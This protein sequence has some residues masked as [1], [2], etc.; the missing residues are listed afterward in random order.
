VLT[1][2]LLILHTAGGSLHCAHCKLPMRATFVLLF[3][4]CWS[5][6]VSALSSSSGLPVVK[7]ATVRR[8][9]RYFCCTNKPPLLLAQPSVNVGIKHKARNFRKEEKHTDGNSGGVLGTIWKGI[10]RFLPGTSKAKLAETYNTPLSDPGNRYHVRLINVVPSH[11]RH[12]VTRLRRYVPDLTWE[13][14]ESMVDSAIKTGAALVRVLNSKV[15]SYSTKYRICVITLKCSWC[16][17]L[18]FRLRTMRRT[19]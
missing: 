2:T 10:R 7:V 17:G 1:V 18:V 9:L 12:T 8:T 13:T 15:R 19:W 16:R 6:S 3:L 14:A 4:Y 11:K 5:L